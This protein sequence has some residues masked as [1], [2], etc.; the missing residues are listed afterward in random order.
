MGA[1]PA[2]QPAGVPRWLVAAR[3]PDRVVGTVLARVPGRAASYRR[4]DVGWANGEHSSAS[5]PTSTRPTRSPRRWPARPRSCSSSS[6]TRRA[7]RA[8]VLEYAG[9]ADGLQAD[10]EAAGVDLYV[11][12]PYIDQRRHDQQP[13]PDPLPQAAAAARR[14]R[15][16][17]RREGADRPRRP[18]RPTTTTR[19]SASTTGARRSRRPTSSSRC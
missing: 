12:A 2:A 9:G 5:A 8:R 19:R 13:H 18:R 17:D 4:C 10:A 1:H 14:R 11:H 6:A 7:T 16:L 3:C 15:R